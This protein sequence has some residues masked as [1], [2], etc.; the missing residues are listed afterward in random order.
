MAYAQTPQ[1]APV[2]KI[3]VTGSRI[4]VLLTSSTSPVTEVNAQDIRFTGLT[5]TADILNRL[6]Q[7]FADYGGN[8]SNAATGTATINLRNLGAARTWC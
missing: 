2:I 4:P 1:A 7:A 5:S 6:P 8:L 3:E